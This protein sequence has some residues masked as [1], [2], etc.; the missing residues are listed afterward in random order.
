ML[1]GLMRSQIKLPPDSELLDWIKESTKTNSNIYRKG[2]QGCVYLY[3]RGEQRLIIKATTGRGPL[4]LIRRGMIRNEYKAYSRLK[5]IKGV[6]RCYRLIGKDYLILEFVDG[7]P[8]RKARIGNREA[9][10][11]GLLRLIKEIHK[12]G[13]A[14]ADLK[15]KDNL[16]LVGD[17]TP[18]IV[19]FGTAVIRKTGFS[20]LNRWFYLT[21]KRFDLNAWIKLKYG[22]KYQ[23]ISEED[24]E[25]YHR[26]MV[27]KISR[28][29]KRLYLRPKRAL[30]N[31]RKRL[32]Q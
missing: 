18:F 4:R 9:Y 27:E 19:D 20:P 5:D 8:Y 16:L 2:Y 22:K 11:Q 23:D 17:H 30:R 14:H 31:I 15:K 13:V 7:I 24:K 12:A 6:P 3:E 26:T 29:L 10:F 28:W 32:G 25:Y 1:V 21:A